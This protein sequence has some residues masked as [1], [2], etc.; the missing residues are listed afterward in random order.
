MEVIKRN[1]N[2][3]SMSFDKITKRIF[4]MIEGNMGEGIKISPLHGRGAYKIDPIL[5][6]KEVIN[7]I[8]N[9]ITTAQID[10]LSADVCASM[11]HKNPDFNHLA[12]RIRIS[13]LQK[14]TEPDIFGA[15]IRLAPQ[16]NP[17]YV[18]FVTK[19]HRELNEMLH[20]SRDFMFDYFGFRTLERSYL[21]NIKSDGKQVIVE[22]PQHMWMRV[23]VQIHGMKTFHPLYMEEPIQKV[24]KDIEETYNLLSTMKFTHATPT[25]FNS[26]SKRQQMS[27][28]FLTNI[29]D[30]IESIFKTISNIAYI[31]KFAGGIGLSI[32]PI[33]AKGSLIRTTNG[34]SEGIVPMCKVIESTARYINQGGKRLGSVAVYLEPWHADVFDFV[35]LRK[36]TGDENLRC[37]D[38]FL[39]LWIPDEFMRRVERDD[40][41]YL[42][43]PDKQ[44]G[45]VDSYGSD[46]DQLYNQYISEGKYMRK[47]R[48]RDLWN[49]I[50]E[51][52]I[53]TGM[54]YI[55]YKDH[56]NRKNNQSNLGTIRNSNLCVAGYTRVLTDKG[57]IRIE[58]IE[59]VP[60][61]VWNGW[62]WST[63]IPRRTGHAVKTVEVELKNGQKLHTTPEHKFYTSRSFMDEE[64]EVSAADLKH[65]DR[66]ASCLYPTIRSQHED[67][68][69]VIMELTATNSGKINPDSPPYNS[70]LLY[71][72]RWLEGAIENPRNYELNLEGRTDR[73]VMCSNNYDSILNTRLMLTTMGCNPEIV[74]TPE[75]TSIYKLYIYVNDIYTLKCIGFTPRIPTDDTVRISTYQLEVKEVKW[76]P[77]VDTFCFTEPLRHRAV[78][79][80]VYTGQCNEIVEYSS[81]KETAVCNLASICLPRFVNSHDRAFD[82]DELARVVRVVVKNLNT[83]IDLNYY[84]IPETER[85]NQSHRPVGL[86][87]QGL[88]DVYIKMRLPFESE[89]ANNLNRQIMETIYY[90]ALYESC[91]LS[92]K[93]GPY[94]SFEG[95]PASNGILQWH[96][97]GAEPTDERWTHLVDKIRT[98][99]LRN[100]L[101]V[102]LM[103]TASTSQICGNTESFEPITSNIYVRKTLAGEF[104][105]VNEHLVK[106]L[107]E[108]GMW[109]K[110]MYNTIL[111]L[112][113]SIQA[114][115]EIP[116][117]IREL[118][119]TAFEIKQSSILKQAA[120]R[121]PFV[122]QTQSMN[123]FMAA[124]DFGKLTS[125]HFYGWKAG[126]KTG[127]Y[128]LRTQPAVDPIKFG[129]DPATVK[130][131]NARFKGQSLSPSNSNRARE[132]TAEEE[133][134]V[135]V[136]RKK[137]EPIPEGC[138][139][140]SA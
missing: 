97:W 45:L 138:D 115:N 48:A 119:K 95:S 91:D 83:I 84:P 137:G 69:T 104:I 35:E 81:P 98:H 31:S 8:Y 96:M 56:V 12:A 135:C 79:E 122:D 13:N 121:G 37:R 103:P 46:F 5:V 89:E 85:S 32:T 1:G 78:F 92:V 39:A 134:K 68:V 24:L 71:K 33:R 62:D 10:D 76:G 126:L 140:C 55:S 11:I 65:G 128:Y 2:R 43:C 58:D 111:Y 100:S 77:I 54:P 109:N 120:T 23:A 34:L 114:I 3:E 117:S 112:N 94:S 38:L 125:M 9:G 22:R 127:M 21:L 49:H 59:G 17:D 136:R 26:G 123:L 41:W 27:S 15:V 47:V 57:Y 14:Q 44:P 86:G 61:N 108:L 82:F 4:N 29:E 75:D 110:D 52:Q 101:L 113:G 70:P 63:V 40:D 99:G 132:E 102:A 130:A 107:M 16:L 124:P 19:Y 7:G 129:L 36:N 28:C 30:D 60:T 50:L 74:H 131:L 90:N 105:V 73:I 25:L 20:F 87:I 139:V 72:V 116:H 18:A 106:D 6:A 42:M 51:A 64:I 66:L 118:Y 53:E 80:G 133:V 67:R 93:Y 88:A